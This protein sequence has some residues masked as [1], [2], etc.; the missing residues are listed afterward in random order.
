MERLILIL[1]TLV[2]ADGDQT[3]LCNNKLWHLIHQSIQFF[4]IYTDSSSGYRFCIGLFLG[5]CSRCLL[6]S[7]LWSF[8][9]CFLLF[10]C[11]FFCLLFFLCFCLFYIFIKMDLFRIYFFNLRNSLC[12]CYDLVLRFFRGKEKAELKLKLLVFD[13]LWAWTVYQN[14]SKIFHSLKYKE[15]TGCLQKTVFLDMN[16]H[17]VNMLSIWLRFTDCLLLVICQ[18][19]FFLSCFFFLSGFRCCFFCFRSLSI[20]CFF[21]TL[22]FCNKII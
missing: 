16:C 7:R 11:R 10:R 5:I 22:C 15:C 8:C 19:D 2:R 9:R 4:N 21:R 3:V 13:I 18:F 6:L 20:P 14:L 17:D 12:Y 1:T